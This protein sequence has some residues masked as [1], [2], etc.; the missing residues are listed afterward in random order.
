MSKRDQADR[1]RRLRS[2]ESHCY[3]VCM[4][5]LQNE[6]LAVQA[7]QD[8]LCDMFSRDSLHPDEVKKTAM[9]HALAAAGKARAA[10]QACAM[11]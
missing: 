9:E 6:A 1:I 7:A 3:S 4:Y 11:A 10:S 8:A 2:V 5:L